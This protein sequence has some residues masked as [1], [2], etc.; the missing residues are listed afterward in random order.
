MQGTI[1]QAFRARHCR[2]ILAP[3][4]AACP[5]SCRLPPRPPIVPHSMLIVPRS[6]RHPH[7]WS[8]HVPSCRSD[9]IADGLLRLVYS[10]SPTV[11]CPHPT[12]FSPT[13]PACCLARLKTDLIQVMFT[14]YR[15]WGRSGAVLMAAGGASLWPPWQ[16]AHLSSRGTGE[17]T[18]E[19][20]T[21]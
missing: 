17:A 14:C 18:E 4:P 12:H 5:P 20:L 9:C 7:L 21:G 8:L 16:L 11:A 15:G 19:T 2:S 10:S 3:Y 1:C 13:C 6:C